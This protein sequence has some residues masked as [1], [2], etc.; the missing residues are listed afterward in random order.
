MKREGTLKDKIHRCNY[1][2][3]EFDTQAGMLRHQNKCKNDEIAQLKMQLE[4]LLEQKKKDDEITQLQ[5]KL[6]LEQKDKMVL[7]AK[8][9]SKEEII[10][11][12]KNQSNTTNTIATKS[13]SALTYLATKHKN[14]P[15]LKQVKYE[16]AKKLLECDKDDDLTKKILGKYGIGRLDEFIGDIIVNHYKKDNPEEQSIWNSDASRLT[17]LIKDIVGKKSEWI[18]DKKGMKLRELVIKPILS[19]V[20]KLVKDW[21]T[22]Q[23]YISIDDLDREQMDDRM[24]DT[25]NA[26]GVLKDIASNK[27]GEDISKNLSPRFGLNKN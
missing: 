3:A 9:E 8:L 15:P 19:L 13:V 11:I 1:C 7:E 18:K 12:L 5:N 25:T 6:Q 24:S 21:Q 14:A 20:E 10:E 23:E 16:D 27:L 17:F 22:E 2:S 26:I 4:M